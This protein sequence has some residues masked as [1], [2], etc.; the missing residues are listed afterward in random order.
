MSFTLRG[1]LETRLAASLA[2]LVGACAV[3]LAL[4]AWWPVELAG[5]MVAVGLALDAAAYHRFLPYQPGWLAL[6]LGALE[7][8]VVMGI[9]LA[10]GVNAPRSAAI[11]FFVG[12]WLLGQVLVHAA[13]PLARLS[14]G[15][16]GGELGTG[17]VSAGVAVVALLAAAGGVGWATQPP[18]VHLAA[19]IHQGPLVI[20]HSEKLVGD[21]GA[22]VRGGIVV[23]SD[24]VTISNVAVTGGEIGI[25]IDGAENVTVEHVRISGTSLDGIQAR[26]A[27]VKIRD[28]LIHSPVGD[29]AQGI[30]ISFGFDL[31]PSLIDGCTIIGGREGIVTHFSNVHISDNHVSGTTLRALGLTEMSMVMVEGNEVQNALGVGIYCGDYSECMI[32]DNVVGGTRPDTTSGD[33][34]RLGFAVVAHS[35]A[36]AEVRDNKLSR[37]SS[38]MKAFLGARITAG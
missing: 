33:L 14:Y 29:Y 2:P 34:T 25:K 26:R 10:L 13:F 36:K 21:R 24:D 18:T 38:R 5:I 3:A 23:T 28:C 11:A 20:D 4:K 12:S 37:N 8:G 30:D 15:E 16:D 27:S 19:G 31:P 6:P 35:G 1:R 22:V 17:G 7:L 9:V 32:E